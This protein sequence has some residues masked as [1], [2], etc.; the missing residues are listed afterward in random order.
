MQMPAAF[1]VHEFGSFRL[2]SAE[3]LLLRE[4]QPVSLTPKAFDL[5]VYLVE[6]AGRLV[7]KQAL[8]G[9]LWPNTSV[10]EANLT[11]TVSALRKA[12]G[13]G[14]DGDQ[15]IQ[16]VPTRGYRFVAP[17]VHKEDWPV[18]STSQT[19]PR[20]FRPLFRRIAISALAVSVVAMSL[21]VVRHMRERT[22]TPA[23]V[24]FT[25]PLPPE[26]T[27]SAAARPLSQISPDGRR[28]ALVATGASIWLRNIDDLN[29]RPVAGTEG[30][31]AVFWAP[32]SDQL[33]FSTESQ[34][35]K[36]R[37]SDGVVQTLCDS[38]QP[39]GG[40]TWSRKDM[41]VF[42]TREGSLL[43]IPAGGGAPQQASRLDSSAGEIS[44][45]YPYFLPDGDRFLYLSRNKDVTRSGLFLGQVGSVMPELLL[46]GDLPAIYAHPGYLLFLRSGT[47]M[48]QRLDPERLALSGDASPLVV[49]ASGDPLVSQLAFSAS[50]TGRLTYSI[51]E[52]PLTQFQWVSRAG[53]L[54]QLVGEPGPY[55]TFDLSADASRLAFARFEAG[56]SNLRVLDLSSGGTTPLTSGASIHADPRWMADG[57]KLFATRWQPLPQ[58]MVQM[59]LDRRESPISASED[60]NMVEDVSRDGK[61]LLY[62]QRA[63]QLWAISLSDGS[64]R[65]AVHKAP[66]GEMNQAQF[67]PDSR[68]VAY[69]SNES[70]RNEVY[71]TRFPSTGEH[72]PVSSGGA[73]Q[74]VWRQ[75]GHELY[76]LG[77]DGTLYGVEMQPGDPPKFLTRSRLFQTG[78]QP[79]DRAEQYAASADGQRFL[80]LKVVDIRNPSRIGVILGWPALLS[81]TLS[82]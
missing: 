54:Q 32:D 37:V 44:H 53:D 72:W 3:R 48:A 9:E 75:D 1:G 25:I 71:V 81:A 59:S 5:L 27:F 13:D 56:Y 52:R 79:S 47:L 57:Q 49:A 14:Q 38:C 61:Y 43:R 64:K 30:A 67:S 60:G 31:R 33:A 17:V 16:T 19:P 80:V 69:H 62:R 21:V 82:R 42:T 58:T 29:L 2:D 28:V 4:G 74:P 51:V 34:L 63:Q 73:V 7:T 12:L 15:F 76:Y 11:F 41:I 50:E 22:D 24:R 78:L 23:A 35:R 18:S 46:A 77:L 45:L 68:W 70:G 39:T 26:F 65:F 36:V 10:E 40:G 66:V 55:S 8:M 6:H 20:S